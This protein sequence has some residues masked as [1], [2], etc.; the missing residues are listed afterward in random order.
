MKFPK[1]QAQRLIP[2]YLL[3][4]T[5]KLNESHP[6]PTES[7][8]GGSGGSDYTAGDGIDI[9]NNVI[10]VDGTI[11][12]KSEIPTNYVT[13]DTE[14]TITGLKT[15]GETSG[16]ISEVDFSGFTFKLSNKAINNPEAD[17]KIRNSSYDGYQHPT[18]YSTKGLYVNLAKIKLGD[19]GNN[20]YGITMPDSTTWETDRVL[21]TTNDIPSLDGYATQ[22]WV[23][24]QG[25]ATSSS[26]ATVAT[27]GNYNDLTNKPDLSIYAQ[28]SNLSTV[29]TTGSYNDLTDK[30]TLATVATSGS[31][32]D[33]S[34]KPYIFPSSRIV[35]IDTKQD[36][37]GIKTFESLIHVKDITHTEEIDILPDS[38][39]YNVTSID[40][41]EKTRAKFKLPTSKPKG[42]VDAPTEYTFATNDD[43]PTVNNPTITFTQGGTTKGTITL[44]QS[45][46]QTIEFD[47]GGGG[48]GSTT[49]MV[50]T[51]TKQE[52]T[53][54]KTFVGTKRIKFKQHYS[55]DRLG[56]TGY[57]AS[58][59]EVGYLEMTKTD[60]DFTGNPTSNILGYWSNI[61]S[62]TNPSSDAMLGFKYFTKDSDGNTRNYKLVVPTR[63]NETSVTRYIPIS[64]NGN[65]A[66]NTGNINVPTETL[67]FTLADNSTVTVN[68]MTGA[69]VS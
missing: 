36:I 50:T 59:I 51:D 56:F 27:T 9:T 29:A 5:T 3:D 55:D 67:V 23:Q 10:S 8:G 4:Y 13:L 44:N 40:T 26:L 68:V 45:G 61:N 66:D 65:T 64:V 6:D 15:I 19:E 33:L 60:R 21:A 62:A 16:T 48:G 20:T 1:K 41:N 63:Y 14:Q 49:N 12:K 35:D 39:N 34:D 69:T 24:E 58:G 38:F 53:G 54:E 52:I 32:N 57:D 37:T 11:A 25:Y 2:E 17:I 43:I 42:T 31:Y 22:T 47:A 28:S 18:I 46:D 30:P 7:W